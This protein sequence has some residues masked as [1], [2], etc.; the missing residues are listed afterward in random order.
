MSLVEIALLSKFLPGTFCFFSSLMG[1]TQFPIHFFYFFVHSWHFFLNICDQTKPLVM[2]SSFFLQLIPVLF[3]YAQCFLH[4][5]SFQKVPYKVV[6]HNFSV[7]NAWFW[8]WFICLYWFWCPT[9]TQ[10]S[11]KSY[12]YFTVSWQ[13]SLSKLQN[14]WALRRHFHLPALLLRH[15]FPHNWHSHLLRLLKS[16]VLVSWY[17]KMLPSRMKASS[18][19][20][21]IFSI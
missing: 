1:N 8:F 21:V 5:K 20:S 4:V 12:L 15:E 14:Y 18:L 6:D 7:N 17:L 3:K 2:E 10:S 13:S 19:K 11:T 16:R 9:F